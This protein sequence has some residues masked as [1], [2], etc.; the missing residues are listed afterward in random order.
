MNPQDVVN[1][2]IEV[3]ATT[4]IAPYAT[5]ANYPIPATRHQQQ[6]P[7]PPE[8]FEKRLPMDDLDTP[9]PKRQRRAIFD[10]RPSS[11]SKQLASLEIAHDGIEQRKLSL[12]DPSLP[13]A[14]SELLLELQNCSNSGVGILSSDMRAEIK[15]LAKTDA[16]FR[17][18]LDHMFAASSE[19]QKLGQTPSLQDT[20]RLVKEA[21]ECQVSR[22]NESGWNM[23][24]HHPLLYLAIYGPQR[25]EQLVGFAPCTT[26]KIILEY[27]PATSK[28]KMVDF[29]VYLDPTADQVATSTIQTLRRSLPFQVINHTEFQPFRKRPI[30]ISVETKSRGRAQSDTAELQLGTWHSAQWRF[31]HRLVSLS[32][33]SFDGLAFLPAIVVQGHDWSFVATTREGHKTVLWLEQPLGSTSNI[34][35]VYKIIWS[36]QR[37]AQW[38]AE[39]YWPWFRQN[40][41]GVE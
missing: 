13:L 40:G 14:L 2:L 1:W 10:F 21:A 24:V 15:E 5:L 12:T 25:L 38:A 11:P 26:A 37:L 16:S 9:A 7:S 20:T 33:G 22:Q 41:L 31:L 4:Q 34:V 36:L 35:G 30:A 39:V 28:A 23:M 18:F 17:V 8:S 29:C 19:R 6:P 3:E 32:G 27:L